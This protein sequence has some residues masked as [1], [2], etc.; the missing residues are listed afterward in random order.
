MI[1]KTAVRCYL[2]SVC[3]FLCSA[4]WATDYYVSPKGKDGD[5]GTSEKPWRTIESV[6]KKALQ[7][8]D[9][10]LFEGGQI[11]TGNLVLDAQDHGASEQPLVITSYGTGRAVIDAGEGTGLRATGCN[12]LHVRNLN[13]LGAGRKGGNTGSG[14]HVSDSQGLEIDQVDVKGFQIGGVNVGGVRHA[15]ITHVYAHHNGSAGINIGETENQWSED[16]YIGYCVAEGNAGDP[17]NLNNHSGNGIVAGIVHGCVIEYCEAMHNGWNMPREGNGP[18]GIWT[19]NADR[20]IIQFCISHDNKSPSWDGGGF[21]ID[22]GVTNSILQYN[23]SYNN[24]GPGYLLCQYYPAPTWKDNIVRYNISYNDGDKPQNGSICVTWY[25]G[26]SDVE[27]YNNTF[28]KDYGS[29][30]TF[31]DT[32][33]PGVRFRNNIFVTGG[34][35]L[36]RGGAEK[37]TFQ[38]NVYWLLAGKP[39]EIDG[40]NSLEAWSNSTAQERVDGKLVGKWCDPLV[41]MPDRIASMKPEDLKTLKEFHLQTASPCIGAGILIEKSGER[42]FWGTRLPEKKQPSIG[43][44]EVP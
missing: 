13:F 44:F 20:V 14:I 4:T 9:R 24:V 2:L 19:W 21:D 15:R 12:F 7:P 39:F 35:S 23:L 8:G 5:P 38:G 6:N 36:I 28:I 27:I 10:V 16:V 31:S 18:V 29:V 25:E 34:G 37:A 32:K 43:A 17:K 33:V 3:V 26:M 42:D 22:G 40:F 30:V 41:V 1:Q 11:F